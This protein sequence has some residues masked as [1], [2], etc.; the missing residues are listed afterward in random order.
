MPAGFAAASALEQI[1]AAI[2][3]AER[4]VEDKVAALEAR[5]MEGMGGLASDA[6]GRAARLLADAE[7]R[8]RRLAVKLLA[9]E[10]IEMELAQK[11]QW[12]LKQWEYLA[13]V[14]EARRRDIGEVG[15]AG[16]SLTN[17]VAKGVGALPVATMA[18]SAAEP[19]AAPAI[20][21]RLVLQPME[22]VETMPTPEGNTSQVDD[23]EGVEREGLFRSK[24]APAL[25]EPVPT[26]LGEKDKKEKDKGK[27]KAVQIA[28]PSATDRVA[29]QW[30]KQAT[31]DSAKAKKP[32]DPVAPIR[33]IPK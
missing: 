23:M 2:A 26:R 14:L 25:G 19:L 33:S 7:E 24:H 22:G 20:R 13:H 32:E 29:R 21:R 8:K 27:G 6:D 31:V 16:D 3:E 5:I 1:L 11:V 9:M 28:T 12:E 17:K 18:L 30:K 10:A 15:Q 4:K